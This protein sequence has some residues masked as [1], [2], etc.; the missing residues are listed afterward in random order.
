MEADMNLL[1]E[2]KKVRNNREDDLTKAV[3][4]AEYEEAIADKLKEIYNA[5]Y[6][7]AATDTDAMK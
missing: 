1:K 2:M 7:S 3:D 4:G 6:N 5:L